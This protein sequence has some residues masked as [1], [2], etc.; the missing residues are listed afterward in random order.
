MAAVTR[1]AAVEQPSI[2]WRVLHGCSSSARPH[3]LEVRPLCCTPF[4]WHARCAS[5]ATAWCCTD[6]TGLRPGPW[7]SLQLSNRARG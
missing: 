7:H 4:W 3:S 6:L 5:A 2:Q 1:V